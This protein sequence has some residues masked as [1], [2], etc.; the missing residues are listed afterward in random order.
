MVVGTVPTVELRENVSHRP[1]V[2]SGFIRKMSDDELLLPERCI[3]LNSIV[4]Q[5]KR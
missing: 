2:L 1:R 4:G 5:G 3:D